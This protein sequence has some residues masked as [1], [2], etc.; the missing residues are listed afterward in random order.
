MWKLLEGHDDD[1]A[2]EL[3]DYLIKKWKDQR[4]IQYGED[5]NYA[6][7]RKE[8][9]A[10]FSF[11]QEKLDYPGV[12]EAEFFRTT[13]APT[14]TASSEDCADQQ[15]FPDHWSANCD[16]TEASCWTG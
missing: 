11:R 13:T 9:P 16:G 14:C 10:K 15:A 6:P 2:K 12:A 3:K 4:A 7:K 5:G 1:K 8:C